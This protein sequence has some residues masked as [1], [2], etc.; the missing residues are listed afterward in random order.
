[1]CPELVPPHRCNPCDFS[2]SWG[3]LRT[4]QLRVD[5]CMYHG[6]KSEGVFVKRAC[7]TTSFH[8]N[9]LCNRTSLSLYFYICRAVQE[10]AGMNP[11]HHPH[12]SLCPTL[13][14]AEPGERGRGSRDKRQ[15]RNPGK[16]VRTAALP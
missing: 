6:R 10:P 2:P 8:K 9:L 3:L 11:W 5:C 1:M 14:C 15:R 12:T 16:T 7:Q 4:P 13:S